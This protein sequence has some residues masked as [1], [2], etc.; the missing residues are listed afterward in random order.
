MEKEY[1]DIE[2]YEKMGFNYSFDKMVDVL[3]SAK[4]K[5]DLVY[6]SF[7]GHLFYSDTITESTA[8]LDYYD[9]LKKEKDYYNNNRSEITLSIIS[10]FASNRCIPDDLYKNYVTSLVS[11]SHLSDA[12][13]VFDCVNKLTENILTGHNIDEVLLRFKGFT[14]DRKEFALKII[15]DFYADEYKNYFI[16]VLG[17]E[18]Y[19][20]KCKSNNL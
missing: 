16:N 14:D 6:C 15:N 8:Y 13:Q 5:G 19:N 11:W 7:N 20:K 18:K 1:I 2:D 4:K 17:L 9:M 3:L 12:L 10:S